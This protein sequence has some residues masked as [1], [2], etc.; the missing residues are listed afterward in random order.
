MLLSLITTLLALLLI[1][2]VFSIAGDQVARRAGLVGLLVLWV[3]VAVGLG[4]A[5]TARRAVIEVGFRYQPARQHPLWMTLL[6]TIFLL[7]LL[8]PVAALL[9]R[10]YRRGAEVVEERSAALAMRAALLALPGLLLATSVALVLDLAGIS[11]L[12]PP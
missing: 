5:G 8:A 11:F 12:P 2:A 9:A 6:F 3:V 1:A 4:V 7:L 10:R